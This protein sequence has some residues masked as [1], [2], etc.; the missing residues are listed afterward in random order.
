MSST[1]DPWKARFERERA[2]RRE[3][4]ALLHEKSREIY[5]TNQALEAR[6]QDLASSLDQLR[7]AQDQLVEQAKMVALGGLVAGVAHEINT[8]V[9]VAVTAMTHA[10]DRL[11]DLERVVAAGTLTRGDMRAFVAELNEAASLTLA[12]LQRAAQLVKSFKKVAVDQASEV[13]RDAELGELT[14]DVV[15]S[16]RPLT[17]RAGVVVQVRLADGWEPV[18]VRVDAGSLVQVLTN[19][20]QNACVHAFNGIEG[21][22]QVSVTLDGDRTAVVLVIAD[23]GRGMPEEV[24]ERVFEPFFT[25]RRSSG[26]SGLGMHITHTIVTQRFQGTIQLHTSPHQ[27]TRWTLR[28]PFGTE[29]LTLEQEST[30]T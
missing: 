2:A 10:V 28:L 6:A 27:G 1:E 8:P 23:N 29:A 4:E 19:L 20:L 13:V 9:G 12:N 7:A 5:A 16:L 30:E 26:G 22:R 15:G 21:S 25:T 18:R 3:A 14:G 17:R 24:A 11:R